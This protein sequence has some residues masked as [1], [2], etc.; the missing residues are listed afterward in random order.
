[1]AMRKTILFT[2]FSFFLITGCSDDANSGNSENDNI[3]NSGNNGNDGNDTGD[4]LLLGSWNM[5][6]GEVIEFD[7][8]GSEEEAQKVYNEIL[9]KFSGGYFKYGYMAT[10]EFS[11]D[12]N[13]Y[14]M[15]T[16]D[17][18][19]G[20][21]YEIKDNRMIIHDVIEGVIDM[22][23]ELEGEDIMYLWRNDAR[24]VYECREQDPGIGEVLVKYKYAR[25]GTSYMPAHET[26]V[27]ENAEIV[28]LDKVYYYDSDYKLV[29][30]DDESDSIIETGI[31]S[32]SGVSFINSSFANGYYSWRDW[33]GLWPVQWTVMKINGETIPEEFKAQIMFKKSGGIDNCTIDGSVWLYADIE[34][35]ETQGTFFRFRYEGMLDYTLPAI[36]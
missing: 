36:E 14:L 7:F 24:S 10:M 32:Y 26:Y 33:D 34:A 31:S 25:S 19:C 27:F 20:R 21:E 12:G 13:V 29:L 2:L 30:K 17:E 1:M 22:E 35:G 5:I 3:D 16:M 15:E 4:N 28:W 6:G 8:N 11:D 18:I 9:K 23:F